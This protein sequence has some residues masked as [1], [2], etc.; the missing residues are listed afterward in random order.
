MTCMQN[1][2]NVC[3]TH[4]AHMRNACDMR[5][6]VRLPLVGTVPHEAAVLTVNVI[7]LIT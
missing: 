1:V 6:L 3:D 2:C 5:A 7:L 4:V